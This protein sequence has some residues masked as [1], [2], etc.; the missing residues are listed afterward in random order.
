MDLTLFTEDRYTLG[1]SGAILTSSGAPAGPSWTRYLDVFD[2][3]TVAARIAAPSGGR[4]FDGGPGVTFHRVPWY[5]GPK[6]Y[7]RRL[8]AIRRA[9]HSACEADTAFILRVPGRLSTMAGHALRRTRRPYGIE[10]V[11]D[12]ADVF[13]P[14]V[15]DHPLR[16][17]F[18]RRF[19][20]DLR[21]LAL[22]AS[23]AAYVTETAL[24]ERYPCPSF[25]IGVSDVRLAADALAN[26]PIPSRAGQRSFRIVTVGSLAQLYKGAD[27]LLAAV[28]ECVQRGLDVTA[29]IVGGGRFRARL[30]TEAEALGLGERVRFTG[31]L[32]AG[33]AVR[34]ELDA[35]DLFVLP[36]R[37]E[38]LPRALIEAMARGLPCLASRVGGI[39][40]L[41][42]E[43]DLLPVG[44]SRALARRI[45][46]VLTSPARR[47]AMAT[48][49]LAR[50]RDFTESLLL[51]RRRTFHEEVLRRTLRSR[52][53][54][55]HHTSVAP[56]AL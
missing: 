23:A 16:S 50:A 54:H 33:A 4:Q 42:P 43:E 24:Q 31:E 30:R 17:F 56:Y 46:A 36:S 39:P 1:T 12:P 44:D 22:H 26:E 14:G 18:R 45:E 9:I 32:P 19:T 55:P 8:P 52:P 27:V 25:R 40:E 3:I 2:H 38:G 41:L 28:A 6:Q 13:A 7:L 10:V 29:V 37:A 11:G 34:A 15:V 49:N 53:P 48:R 35:A 5:V 51:D 20:G 21:R 47:D